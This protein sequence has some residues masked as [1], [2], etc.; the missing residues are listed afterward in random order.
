MS[1]RKAQFDAMLRYLGDAYYQTI[2]DEATASD[3]ARALESDEAADGH[4]HAEPRRRPHRGR[5]RV[6][7]VITANV[8]TVAKATRTRRSPGP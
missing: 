2:H 7:D 1:N 6:S 3:V 4:A 5:W 8:V